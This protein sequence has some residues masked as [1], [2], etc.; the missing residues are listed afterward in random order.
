MLRASFWLMLT[1]GCWLL[2]R[3]CGRRTRKTGL[4]VD[5]EQSLTRRG[6][7]LR[8]ALIALVCTAMTAFGLV[9]LSELVYGF[10]LWA[11]AARYRPH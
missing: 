10:E 11:E 2:Y 9:T 8:A 7:W 6:W 3:R 1:L 4:A 5:G